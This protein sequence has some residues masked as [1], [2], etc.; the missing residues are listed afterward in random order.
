MTALRERH[1][2]VAIGLGDCAPNS[3]TPRCGIFV[4]PAS[5]LLSRLQGVV[6]TGQGWRACCPAHGS[7]SASLSIARGDNGTLLVHCFA[8]CQIC[9]VLAAVSLRVGDLFVR[10]DIRTMS[11]AERSQLRQGALL[12]RWRAA[13]EVLAHEATIV[14]IAADKLGSLTML[15]DEELSRLR[16]AALRTF[17]AQEVLRARWH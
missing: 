9:D 4:D 10:R 1:G 7:K 6:K 12:P 5:L 13:L 17:D 14:L 2:S 15:D 11:A 16:L 3:T 8:G